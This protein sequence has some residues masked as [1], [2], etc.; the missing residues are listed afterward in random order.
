LQEREAILARAKELGLKLSED[1]QSWLPIYANSVNEYVADLG[2]LQSLDPGVKLEPKLSSLGLNYLAFFVVIA[3]SFGLAM[4]IITY[5]DN[6]V[7][8]FLTLFILP[9]IY[10]FIVSDKL[11]KEFNKGVI[12]TIFISLP[13]SFLSYLNELKHGCFCLFSCTCPPKPYYYEYP[14]YTSL[15]MAVLLLIYS[16]ALQIK[17]KRARGFGVFVGLIISFVIFMAAT[18]IGFWS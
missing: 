17:G 14:M 12:T 4:L 8:F 9:I 6:I 11:G 15:T 5:S 18:V 7:L 3:L 10:S 2:T 16:I 1:G 13:F